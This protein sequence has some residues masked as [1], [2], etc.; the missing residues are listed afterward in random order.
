[1][2]PAGEEAG[3]R[4]AILES[5]VFKFHS[6]RIY[7]SRA[8]E[9]RLLAALEVCGRFYNDLV[10]A[11]LAAHRAGDSLGLVAQLRQVAVFR[12]TQP[13]AGEIHSHTLQII[14]KDVNR[15]WRSWMLKGG[16]GNGPSLR[17]PGDVRSF[18]FA[19]YK[20]GFAVD[21]RRLRLFG[22]GRLA[23]RWHRALEGTVKT[24]RIYQ[25]G[26]RWFAS[27]CSEVEVAALPPTG[28]EIGIDLGVEYL[29]TTSAGERVPNPRWARA[30]QERLASLRERVKRT[31]PGSAGHR[32]AVARLR[33]EHIRIGDRRRDYLT[34]VAS[35]LVGAYDRIAIERLDVR[36]LAARRPSISDAGFSLFS[37]LLQSAAE[38]TGRVVTFVSP[39]WTSQTCAACGWRNRRYLPLND[40]QFRCER[41]PHTADRDRNAA[42]VVLAR[43][44][45]VWVA[46]GA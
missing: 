8:Q 41:C 44:Q 37:R 24:L 18:G 34:K 4:G 31:I 12:R 23:V 28:Q 29:M 5:C 27:F 36:A 7:P 1:V 10:A 6:Y 17:Q 16:R 39:A 32:K 42:S 33:R 46:V 3:G 45:A 19:Q 21:G 14:A 13:G 22:I 35:A 9:R 43:A 2:A 26:G 20:N 30:A 25:R 15:A 40:R 38:A 11:R